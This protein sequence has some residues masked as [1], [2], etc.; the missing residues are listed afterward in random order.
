METSSIQPKEVHCN[1]TKHSLID[2]IFIVHK[3]VRN[4]SLVVGLI[5]VLKTVIF[6][7]KATHPLF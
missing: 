4:N 6:F 1:L 3:L 7:S 5:Q 2:H